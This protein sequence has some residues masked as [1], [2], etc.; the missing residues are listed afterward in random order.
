M[1]GISVLVPS[2]SLGKLC[3]TSSKVFGIF[4]G[5]LLTTS[6]DF[7]VAWLMYAQGLLQNSSPDKIPET[8]KEIIYSHNCP[9]THSIPEIVSQ[10]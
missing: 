7:Q 9:T 8:L 1:V 2:H 10:V 4:Y 5:K 3:E 6:K